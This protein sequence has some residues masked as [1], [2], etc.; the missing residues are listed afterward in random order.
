M[1]YFRGY[2]DPEM[3][4]TRVTGPPGKG[5][6]RFMRA[7]ANRR[8]YQMRMCGCTATLNVKVLSVP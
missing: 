3:V 6:G 2:A 8:L 4:C 5:V 7:V 1:D